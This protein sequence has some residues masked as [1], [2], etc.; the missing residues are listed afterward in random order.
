[1]IV[2]EAASQSVTGALSGISCGV[3]LA[4]LLRF[5]QI[6]EM[7]LLPTYSAELL[8]WATVFVVLL[9]EASALLYSALRAAA[10]QPQP[11]SSTI[12]KT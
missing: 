7:R 9:G 5:V 11:L 8:I 2:Q 4:E 12:V 6:L 3:G 1:M 10:T